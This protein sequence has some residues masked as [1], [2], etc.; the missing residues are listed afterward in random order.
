[1]CWLIPQGAADKLFL[2]SIVSWLVLVWVAG[3]LLN[4]CASRCGSSTVGLLN[5]QIV[6]VAYG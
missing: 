6:S 3:V 1:M 2:I 4:M 5:P